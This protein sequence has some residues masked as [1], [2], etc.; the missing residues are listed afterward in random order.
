[1]SEPIVIS[2]ESDGV[3]EVNMPESR[4]YA[5]PGDFRGC[6]FK[7]PEADAKVRGAF[8]AQTS[9]PVRLIIGGSV[10]SPNGGLI[11]SHLRYTRTEQNEPRFDIRMV[12]P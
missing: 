10:M 1:M 5:E 3:V 2:L 12:K 8:F 6:E 11:V 9:L 4:I 7:S